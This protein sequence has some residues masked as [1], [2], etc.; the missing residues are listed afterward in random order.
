M[1]KRILLEKLREYLSKYSSGYDVSALKYIEDN[2]LDCIDGEFVPDILMQIYS[3][4]G[5]YSDENNFYLQHVNILKQNFDIKTNILDIASGF[6]PAFGNLLAQEQLKLGSGTITLYD[7]ALVTQEPK[8]RNMKLNKVLFT[9][10]MSV[11]SYDL[12]TG[13]LPCDATE[14]IIE[15]ACENRKNFYVAMCGCDHSNSAYSSYYYGQSYEEYYQDYVIDKTEEL[16]KK[17]GNGNLK[18]KRLPKHFSAQYPILFNQK[19]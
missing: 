3:E 2:F 15:K 18:I 4:L 10:D 12:I 13:I 19:K 6:M 17:Y 11:E 5:I 16:L 9:K 14:L 8:Y 7:P 1:K